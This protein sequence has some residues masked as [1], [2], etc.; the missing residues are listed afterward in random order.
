MS[1]KR[2]QREI[3]SIAAMGAAALMVMSGAA[4][5]QLRVAAWNIT[6][7]GGGREADLAN[8]VYGVYQGRQFAPDVIVVQEVTSASANASLANALNIAA[9]SPGDW[10]A[11]PF[12]DGT[13]SDNAMVY[14]TSKL[15]FLGGFTIAVG[16]SSTTNQPRDTD[17]YDLRLVGY[18]SPGASFSFYSSHMKAQGGTN[19][20][21]RRLIEAQ[22]I[23]ANAGREDS[24][25][26]P[27]GFA[28]IFGGDTN[29][30]SSGDQTY[31]A[32]VSS[33]TNNTG[34]FFD[35]IASPGSWNNNGTYRLIHTQ[36]PAGGGGVDDR[37][38]Q[39]L[40]SDTLI[41]GEGL[42]YIGSPTIPYR[43]Y[44]APVAGMPMD[45]MQ[46]DDPLHSYRCWGN[47]GTSFNLAL[48][49]VETSSNGVPVNRENGMVGASIAQ[50]LIRLASGG[51]H[52][53]V[54]LDL[55]V[56]AKVGA[57]A[58]IDLGSVAQFSSGESTLNVGN[59]GDVALW[60]ANGIAALR[61]TLSAGGDVSAPSGQFN[62]PAG[63]GVNGHSISIDTQ[64]TGPKSGTITIASNDVDQP[65]YV[66]TVT[67][68]V[69]PPA[70]CPGDTNGDNA[71]NSADL[72]VLLS[73][74]NQS[75]TP[76]TGADFNGDGLVNAADLSVLLA[77]FGISC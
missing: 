19:D 63:G 72:S 11:A 17:R 75:V 3:T 30:Q 45:N 58:T 55:R 24:L 20:S 67:A 53:P 49:T 9:G 60:T 41:D 32:L 56:P 46:W 13:D 6:S 77:N 18:S 38:D 1:I 76:N 26:R 4:N 8:A 65:S 44:V 12:T 28:F 23:R 48:T 70:S 37:H 68:F 54:Y 71:I 52:L 10:V 66:V 16:S 39:L 29:L 74:F 57:P 33:Q 50:S 15:Q 40:V 31:Q 21:G 47:D 27:E 25:P 14:R 7:Y 64:T 69:T 51:G 35:P 62:D 43:P 36:D 73:Q 59:A 42:D 34:R 61:Y 22:R 5:A 2:K